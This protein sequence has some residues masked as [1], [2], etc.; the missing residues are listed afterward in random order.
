MFL[1]GLKFGLGLWLGTIA[2]TALV[3]AIFSLSS[4]VSQLWKTRKRSPPREDRAPKGAKWK[5]T[6]ISTSRD[7][8][9]FQSFSFRSVIRWEDWDDRKKPQHQDEVR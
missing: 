1:S 5:R 4:W 6:S 8:G 2:L 3:M 9:A 7:D